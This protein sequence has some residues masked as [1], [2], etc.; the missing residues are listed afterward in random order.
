MQSSTTFAHGLELAE[1]AHHGHRAALHHDETIREQ[2][3]RLER[4]AARTEQ[5]LSALH[6]LLF[7]PR[8][9]SDLDDVAVDLV[10]QQAQRHVVRN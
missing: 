5:P 8:Q 10:L 6:E 9:T 4:V 3:Q 1:V 7:V 2:L